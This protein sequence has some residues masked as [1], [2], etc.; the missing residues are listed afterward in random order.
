MAEKL[1]YM[2]DENDHEKKF[3]NICANV[4]KILSMYS[5]IS[6]KIEQYH[7]QI[8]HKIS[9][10]DKYLNSI[11]TEISHL[12]SN[13]TKIIT[14]SIIES[15]K[16]K[17][18]EIPHSAHSSSRRCWDCK[19]TLN[20][21]EIYERNRDLEK[22]RLSKLWNHPY[23]QF[24]C[25]DCFDRIKQE[26]ISDER[27][28]KSKLIRKN[29]KPE[30]REGLSFIERRIG[31]EIVAT[32]DFKIKSI[33]YWSR[34]PEFI[35]KDKHIVA[36]K[37]NYC[38]LSSIPI[39]LQLF[40][41]LNYLDLSYNHIESLPQWIK[42]MVSLKQLILLGNPIVNIPESFFLI[43]NL[44]ILPVTI[45]NKQIQE[46]MRSSMRAINSEVKRKIGCEIPVKY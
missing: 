17:L 27:R 25:C 37:L 33:H 39:D 3:N 21:T 4:E 38:D 22:E 5:N 40:T 42:F 14:P 8:I 46:K 13:K 20:F 44:E 32:T 24:Y 1:Q 18:V 15:M 28:E 23:I 16:K 9:A 45:R 6:V 2:S 19:K 7:T 43:K 10:L 26:E 34:I 36:L 35:A 29:L 31:K 12:E 11:N 30:E 41:S